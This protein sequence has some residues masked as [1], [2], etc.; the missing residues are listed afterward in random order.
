MDKEHTWTR[1]KTAHVVQGLSYTNHSR[2]DSE[3]LPA[4]C[5][6]GS[7]RSF[8]FLVVAAFCTFC[9]WGI[10]MYFPWP[11]ALTEGTSQRKTRMTLE[12]CWNKPWILNI[13]TVS[14]RC[15]CCCSC[16]FYPHHF[17]ILRLFE[18]T[19]TLR[20]RWSWHWSNNLLRINSMILEWH[21]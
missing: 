2:K 8:A 13:A 11:G 4:D 20:H 9:T 16:C 3:L 14:R 6:R 1:T 15:S 12:N 18:T 19:K 5:L 10:Y 7:S 21:T 17:D